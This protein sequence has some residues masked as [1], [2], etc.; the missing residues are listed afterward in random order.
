MDKI[1]DPEGAFDLMEQS[2]S[3]DKT[4]I[5]LPNAGFN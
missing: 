1:V 2:I 4:L 3:K 5:F